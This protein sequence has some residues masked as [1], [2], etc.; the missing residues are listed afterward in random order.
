MLI[1]KY[2]DRCE[3]T[4][5]EINCKVYSQTS[6]DN[7]IKKGQTGWGYRAFYLQTKV[8]EPGE[9]QPSSKYTRSHSPPIIIKSEHRKLSLAQNIP[10]P[11]HVLKEQ[12]EGKIHW[13]TSAGCRTSYS[14]TVAVTM[15]QGRVSSA[16]DGEKHTYLLLP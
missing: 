8:A 14:P 16:L 7:Q 15:G 9:R 2:C 13:Y 4:Y 3:L 6:G 10:Y 5:V 12:Q 11:T 1:P